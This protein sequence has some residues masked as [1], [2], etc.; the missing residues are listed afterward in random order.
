[1]AARPDLARGLF[2]A[3][4]DTGVG[5][6][7]VACALLRGFAARGLRVVAMKPVAAGAVRRRGV[8]HNDDVAQL[9]AAANVDMP[10]AVI[11]PYCFAP[12]IAPHIAAQA[13]GVKIRMAVIAKNYARL[14]RNADLV[15]VEGAGGLLVPLGGTFSAADIPSRL[16]LPVVLVVG[17]RLGCLNHALLSVEALQARG[18]YLAGWIA[19][20]IDPAMARAAENLQALRVRIK[21]PLLGTVRHAQNPQPARVARLLDIECLEQRLQGP[22]GTRG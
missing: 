21:A 6:T 19:N 10:Q 11:N 18:V 17:L 2:V 12:A 13:S 7:L 20:R 15:V 3:G 14:G 22:P 8:W 4:T 16:N 9:R 5:K 1:M